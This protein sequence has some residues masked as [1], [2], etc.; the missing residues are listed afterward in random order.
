M[1]TIR[2]SIMGRAAPWATPAA[3]DR[4]AGSSAG[5]GEPGR[6]LEPRLGGGHQVMGRRRGLGPSLQRPTHHPLQRSLVSLRTVTVGPLP[7]PVP[8]RDLAGVVATPAG[9]RRA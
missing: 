2:P 8:G 1:P 5:H 6:R 4:T 7:G 3:A 9:L